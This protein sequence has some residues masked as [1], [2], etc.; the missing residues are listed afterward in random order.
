MIGWPFNL[1]PWTGDHFLSQFWKLGFCSVSECPIYAH[2]GWIW[3]LLN[4]E[5]VASIPTWNLPK[6]TWMNH[7]NL[8][9]MHDFHSMAW[10][11]IQQVSLK[12]CMRWDSTCHRMMS[13]AQIYEPSTPLDSG[14]RDSD[15]G[16]PLIWFHRQGIIFWSI[17]ET[18]VLLSKW[19]W[20]FCT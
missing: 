17:L 9:L 14:N 4:R 3:K 2:R 1:G 5:C 10:V 19:M 12:S 15:R 20:K 11:G 18:R 8:V 16:G 13:I 7:Q 6:H